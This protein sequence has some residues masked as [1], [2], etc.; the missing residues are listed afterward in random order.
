[1]LAKFK[2]IKDK[3]RFY[4]ELATATGKEPQ[5]IQSNWFKQLFCNVPKDCIKVAEN[6]IDTFIEY[7]KELDE[8]KE[9]LHIK[10]FGK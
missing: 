10:Y 5:S 9:K 7:E 1:M 6:T 2:K 4:R 3:P 8:I